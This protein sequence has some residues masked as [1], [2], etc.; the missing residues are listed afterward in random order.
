MSVMQKR[1]LK[2][3]DDDDAKRPRFGINDVGGSSEELRALRSEV[4]ELRANKITLEKEKQA[5]TETIRNLQ[6]H[7][8]SQLQTA[9]VAR[10]KTQR[11]ATANVQLVKGLEDLVN[12]LAHIVQKSDFKRTKSDAEEPQPGAKATPPG[13]NV[14]K[15][16]D[17][18]TDLS[19]L[20]KVMYP[21]PEFL[22]RFTIVDA[23]LKFMKEKTYQGEDNDRVHAIVVSCKHKFLQFGI[24]LTPAE[25][26]KLRDHITKIERSL[27]EKIYRNSDRYSI[28]EVYKS[29]SDHAD[30]EF[31]SII[32][33]NDEI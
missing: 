23:D 17:G 8:Q 22:N 25:C 2:T 5:D 21:T 33:L 12:G 15:S 19:G 20:L 18:L 9:L 28:N 6:S 29:P 31:I 30:S 3:E 24:I 10:D 16:D 26:Q 11:A 13:A 4:V 32:N 14:T 1:T 27:H 7:L